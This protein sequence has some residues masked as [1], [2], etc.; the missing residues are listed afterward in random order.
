LANN[1]SPGTEPAG[2]TISSVGSLLWMSRRRL[3]LFLVG[4][5]IFAIGVIFWHP[6]GIL[7]VV[8]LAASAMPW[9]KLVKQIQPPAN[10]R[11]NTIK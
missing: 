3:Q 10:R 6:I 8:I 7:G 2:V 11:A 1:I 9:K 5:V 4:V